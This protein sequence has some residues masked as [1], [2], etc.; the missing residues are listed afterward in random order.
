MEIQHVSKEDYSIHWP[1]PPHL[2]FVGDSEKV[3][4][5]EIDFRNGNKEIGN[6]VHFN[7]REDYL[8]F[9][10]HAAHALHAERIV[11]KLANVKQ[12]RLTETVAVAAS[13]LTSSE[14]LGAFAAPTDV[15]VYN[16]E[17]DDG[18][19]TSGETSG[20]VR[21][22]SGLFLYFQS[23][24][25]RLMRVFI[26]ESS[27]SY[28]QIGDPI[29]KLLVD[30]NVVSEEQMKEAV[31]KQQE[32][33]KLVLGDYLIEQGYITSAEL[34]SALEYQKKRPKLRLG[35]ALI[36][37]GVLS[38]DALQSAL[39]RQRAN[40]GRPLSQILM[41]MGALDANTL[42]KVHAKQLGLPFVSLSN[43]K[44]DPEA[45]KLVPASS[46]QR[47]RILPLAVEDGA[48]IVAMDDQPNPDTLSELGLVARMRIVP[49]IAS[50]EDIRS[51]QREYYGSALAERELIADPSSI[52]FASGA[53]A[54]QD[55]GT[56]SVDALFSSG[57]ELD[58]LEE[59]AT[60]SDRILVR[61]INR[62]LE[63][64]LGGGELHIEIESV[65]GKRRTQ[66]R[67]RP[68]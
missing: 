22:P 43:V 54:P 66:I 45:L 37:M 49:V 68:G 52:R 32:M 18:E 17:F 38:G 30:E 20:Y 63:S 2:K 35:E 47:L 50:G 39:E 9:T 55:S 58:L 57:H 29:A 16:V 5:C 21:M 36:E 3:E 42:K 44:V 26:P 61:V 34:D 65:G 48:L 11:V 8:I 7:A 27:I 12:I 23:S 46:A 4:P 53:V 6:V 1:E 40:R 28:F 24:G 41:D 56:A 19:I 14:A 64:A 13:D 60:G 15:Q 25:N 51:K 67:Y 62:M 31:E 33:R 10:P 59:N